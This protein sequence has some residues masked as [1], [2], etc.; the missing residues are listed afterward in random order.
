MGLF[1]KLTGLFVKNDEQR[2]N[3]AFA[4]SFIE[5]PE[6]WLINLIHGGVHPLTGVT[7]NKET[8]LKVSALYACLKI[9]SETVA[10][11]PFQIYKTDKDG[12]ESVYYDHP[13]YS[14]IH[15]EPNENQS[16]FVYKQTKMIH[17]DTYGNAYSRIRRDRR[18][19]EV[20]SLDI[21]HPSECKPVQVKGKTW[22][23][24]KDQ[25]TL[26]NSSEILHWMNFS[27]D[28]YTG[29]DPITAQ[30]QTLHTSLSASAYGNNYFVNGSHIGGVLE[31]DSKPPPDKREEATN[32]LI[33]EFNR[34][35]SG[36]GNA[37][38]TP[39]LWNGV[40]FK[41][42]GDNIKDSML[43]DVIEMGVPEIA[44][45]YRI[46]LALIKENNGSAA[47]KQEQTMLQLSHAMLP[48]ARQIE[49]ECNRKLLTSDEKST[50]FH[51]LNM[52]VLLRADTEAQAA[53]LRMMFETHSIN[54]NEIRKFRGL[55]PRKDGEGDRYGLPLASNVKLDSNKSEKEPK[56]PKEEKKSINGVLIKN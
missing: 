31:S 2:H 24:L 45:A 15:S 17:L 41:K 53:I 22:Y 52:D 12:N 30:K 44:R 40:K 23:K 43:L 48:T 16:A 35:H 19:G 36:V 47:I 10:S 33:K 5:N 50:V 25:D 3:E 14:I 28:G 4:Q 55:P 54:P 56:T 27:Y 39:V 11:F 34:R 37:G 26:V 9:R 51:R 29:V 21:I 38:S 7:V 6:P 13:L 1:S 18:T 49:E 32:N 46:P 8:A 20:I 42:T